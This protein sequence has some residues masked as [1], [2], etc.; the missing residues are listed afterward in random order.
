M[1]HILSSLAALLLTTLCME[2]AKGPDLKYLRDA[3]ST[4]WGMDLPQFDPKTEPADRIFD[5]AS[6]SF[7]A[8]YN[9]I[10]VT[11]DGI[12]HL[13]V[14][15]L[16]RGMNVAENRVRSIRRSMVKINKP[17]AL[18]DFSDF[19]FQPY[20]YKEVKAGI[21]D[22]EYK[23]AFGARIHKPD[24]RVV[25]VDMSSTLTETEGK[26]GKSAVV[27][28]I[29]IPG[30]E[31]GDVMEFF[32]LTD[33]FFLGNQNVELDVNVFSKY[34]I[35]DYRLDLTLDPKLT[36]II[37]TYNGLEVVNRDAPDNLGN[38]RYHWQLD[39]LRAFDNP[40]WSEPKR[41]IPYV[42]VSISDN[43]SNLYSTLESKRR[44]SGAF[45]NIP[46]PVILGEVAE[47]FTKQKVDGKDFS[48]AQSLV[49]NFRKS[50]PEATE[51][52]II[53]AAWLSALYTTLKSDNVYTEWGM[54]SLFKD[55]L[56][57]Q[58]LE[59]PVRLGVTS[60][61][62]NVP[63]DQISGYKQATP[64]VMAGERAFV[65]TPNLTLYPG[66]LPGSYSGE[67]V[68]LLNGKRKELFDKKSYEAATLPTALKKDNARN[69]KSTVSIPD[70][71]GSLVS[72][73]YTNTLTG[74]YKILG[75]GIVAGNDLLLELE[76]FLDV[77]ASDRIKDLKP[78]KDADD[79]R[80]EWFTILAKSDFAVENIELVETEVI[81]KGFMPGEK[82][83]GYRMKFDADGLVS[84]AGDDLIVNLGALAVNGTDVKDEK[85]ERDISIFTSG[86]K[87][88]R[89]EVEFIV[90]D[91]YEVD[92]ASLGDLQSGISNICGSFNARTSVT[93][94]GNVRMMIRLQDNKAIY[95]P[96][97]WNDFL[98]LKDAVASFGTA[99]IVL[100]KK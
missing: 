17:G 50:H 30:L 44:S 47:V 31:V 32:Y 62:D 77:P 71:D 61:R 82:G 35:A 68:Y 4:V 16:P 46:I 64:M 96:S 42:H 13:G 10:S 88:E 11:S 43:L 97:A 12:D 95:P 89:L 14:Y 34:P 65:F 7:I 6:A 67:M 5:D 18:E 29:A 23:Q 60:P 22:Y 98:D 63:V 9:T 39:N 51:D 55:L 100:H 28:K 41:Q 87:S 1:K 72:V 52:E 81:S 59:T 90:P 83:L 37:N 76:K 94:D 27:H 75:I 99:S 84:T 24:G 54:V 2:A 48:L 8:V 57:K 45:V 66:E 74:V 73:D 69:V 56:D 49:K 26:K 25:D 19:T 21:P 53:D 78:G 91:G 58:A 3:A 36:T 40:R 85:R 33:Y 15:Q 86:P 38:I 93:D 20:E 79:R 92:S 70:V 80:K